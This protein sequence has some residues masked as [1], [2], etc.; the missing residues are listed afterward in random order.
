MITCE[1]C[2][3]CDGEFTYDY[4]Y[5]IYDTSGYVG[6]CYRY[7]PV[8]TNEGTWSYPKVASDDCCGEGKEK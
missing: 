2:I 7:P 3:F 8:F 5:S 1:K 4:G 6:R